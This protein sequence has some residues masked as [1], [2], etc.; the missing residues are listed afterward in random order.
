MLAERGAVEKGHVQ[1]LR[2]VLLAALALAGAL[3]CAGA[4]KSSLTPTPTLGAEPTRTPT[5]SPLSTEEPAVTATPTL[6]P[7]PTRTS[8]GGQA[9]TPTASRTASRTPTPTNVPTSTHTPSPTRTPTRTPLP[10]L[11]TAPPTPRGTFAVP[12]SEFQGVL[13]VI[14]N[15]PTVG[16]APR[17]PAQYRVP[18]PPEVRVETYASGLE[19]PW[20]LAF[21]PDGRLFVSERPGRIRVVRDGVVDPEPWRVLP[22]LALGEGGLMGIA[23]HPDF[24]RQPWLYACYTI[25]AG[26][27]PQNRISRIR[28]VEGRGA[29]EEILLDRFPGAAIHNGCRLLFGPDGRLYATTGDASQRSLAQDLGSLAGKVLRLEP[30]GSIPTD[31]PFGSSPV[32]TLGHRNPQGLAFDPWTGKLFS[33]EHGPSGEHGLRNYDEVNVLVP[34]ANYGWPLA[35]GAPGLPEFRDPLLAYPDLAVPPAGATFYSGR[36]V[37]E[38]RGNFFFTSLR[39]VHLQRVVLDPS[40]TEV[41]AIE[42]LFETGT[43]QGRFGRLRDVVEGPDGALYVTTSNRDGRG[44][45]GPEDD[46]ILRLVPRDAGAARS[47]G[48]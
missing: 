45:P 30:D 3:G 7:F 22:V 23:L 6:S 37:P 32:F 4:G 1:V 29:E 36:L 12:A 21:S 11:P 38:W 16:G 19:V 18:D 48:S 2:F 10:D 46:R 28:E 47:G 17:M 5:G 43:F 9:P 41:W 25:D 44:Q 8:T 14:P 26:G 34:G 35:V 24:P 20:S 40:R 15:G 31:N 13:R 39:G 27:L 33:T 42:R